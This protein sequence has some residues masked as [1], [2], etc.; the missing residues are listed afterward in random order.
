[1]SEFE[2][3]PIQPEEAR[4]LRAALLRYADDP[5]GWTGED[6]PEALLVGGFRNGRLVGFASVVRQRPPGE[7]ER[8]AWRIR[9]IAV[10]H[11]HRGY[12][13]GG[14]MLRRCL[15]HAA[16][17]G[18]RIAWGRVPAGVYGFF[19][20]FGFRRDGDPFEGPGGVPHYLIVAAFAPPTPQ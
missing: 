16:G 3:R 18:G 15:E 9:S 8:D 13:L 20:H 14:L 2:V 4:V 7:A 6:D 1:M 17:R 12:G 19:Q 10:D 5:P 11:G